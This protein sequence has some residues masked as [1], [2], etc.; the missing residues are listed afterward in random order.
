MTAD[1]GVRRFRLDSSYRRPAAGRVVI[2]GSPLRLLTVAEAALPLLE[3]LERDGAVTARGAGVDRLLDRFVDLGIVHP[4]PHA[5]IDATHPDP[6]TLL[7][8]VVPCRRSSAGDAPVHPRWRVPS[9]L[10]DDASEPPLDAPDGVRLVRLDV[11]AG[12]GGARDAGL[13]EVTTP[14]VAFVD[15]DVELDEDELVRLL[16]WFDDP[17]IALVAPRVR[18]AGGTSALARFET[19][20]SPLDLGDEPARVAPTTRVSYVPA[21]V[22]VAR[23]EALRAVGGF[24]PAL[25]WGEDVDLVWRLVEAGWRCRYDPSVVVRHRTRRSWRAWLE[26]RVRYGTSAAPLAER[27]PGALAP[28]RMSGWSAATWAP[29]AAGFP[30]VGVGIGVGTAVAL[31][32]KVRQVPAAEALRLAG[33]GNL[34]AG[35]L[36]ATTLTRVWWPIAAL[37]SAVSPRARRVV[38]AAVVVPIVL[39]LKR[40]RPALDPVRYA[41]LHLAD[42]L[43][44]GSGVWWG[45][46]R[47]RTVAPLAPTFESWPPRDGG[48]N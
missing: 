20:R 5:G 27:H 29:V 14:F 48:R 47:H 41:A 37:A 13:A 24:D 6:A 28:V 40:E 42:D 45:A 4:L 22:V 32:R 17:R 12:P 21:A 7:T 18:A 19:T 43:A 46:W 23:V 31:V 26:Q 16:A 9:V 44:Y 1:A 11:N 2:G 15:A 34:W 10:V 36:L 25:R 35:R 8:V 38:L 3:Q 30:L 33:L 39:D